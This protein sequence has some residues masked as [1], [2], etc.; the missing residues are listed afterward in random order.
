MEEILEAAAVDSELWVSM[1]AETMKTFPSTGSLNTDLN[2]YDVSHKIFIDM[3]TELKKVVNKTNDLGML[4]LEC[5]YLNKTA[6]TALV[7][8]RPEPTKHFIVKRKPKS[9]YLRQELIQK[10]MDAQSSMKKTS[11]PTVPLRS[12]GIPRKMTDTTPMKGIPSRVPTG[13]FRTPPTTSQGNNRPSVSRTPAGRKD[14]GIKLL[15]IEDQPLGYAAAK[16]RKRQQ[17]LEEQQ[18]RALESQT[19]AATAETPAGNVTPTTLTA[20]STTA[21]GTPTTPTTPD[22][23]AG[24]QASTVFSQPATPMPST[25]EK[26]SVESVPVTSTMA[27]TTT[28]S[29][30]STSANYENV[31]AVVTASSS[32]KHVINSNNLKREPEMSPKRVKLEHSSSGLEDTPKK[33]VSNHQTLVASS[34]SAPQTITV[35]RE[36]KSP[37]ASQPQIKR[38]LPTLI[39]STAVPKSQ[40]VLTPTTT[41]AGQS[42]VTIK[43]VSTPMAGTSGTT[44]YSN[45]SNLNIPSTTKIVRTVQY[46]SQAPQTSTTQKSPA[47]I[48]TSK[49]TLTLTKTVNAG[50]QQQISKP[51]ILSNI[52]LTPQQTTSTS[53]APTSYT[54]IN[55]PSTG[56]K[57][58]QR[59]VSGQNINIPTLTRPAQQTIIQPMQMNQQTPTKIVQIQTTPG[60]LNQ[61]SIK[62]IPPLISTQQPTTLLNFQNLQNIQNQGARKVTIT[63]Q[64]GQNQSGIQRITLS[65]AQAAVQQ[66]QQQQQNQQNQQGQQTQQQ[67]H[68]I[69]SANPQKIT[70]VMMPSNVKGKTIILTNPNLLTQKNSVILQSVGPG[71]NSVYQQIPIQNVS[72]LTGLR[73]ATI[74]TNP[75]GLIKTGGQNELQKGNNQQIPALV[76]TSNLSTQNIPGLTPVVIA[77]SNQQ[78]NQSL[79]TL[80]T[81]MSSTQPNQVQIRPVLTTMQQPQL[82]LIQRPGQQPQLVQTIQPQQRTIITQ[83]PQQQTV[84]TVQIQ[85]QPTTQVVQQQ[86]SQGSGTTTTVQLNQRKGLSLSVSFYFFIS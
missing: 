64:P 53:Q 41:I 5:Q 18:K 44:T 70:Q 83:Q 52:V 55:S 42:Y 45:L 80:I 73:G 66:Q 12:R 10:S 69:T 63:Q 37:I 72:G 22:Y 60:L 6:L 71:G 28:T 49:P 29:S 36:I 34:S 32:L 51:T 43:A 25:S 30:I 54:V 19:N 74:V 20:T 11:A 40:I 85:Q 77:T 26:S 48:L 39:T 86:S 50:Q 65:Q 7:G 79:P 35:T 76:P 59:V 17:D 38:T 62:N 4:P 27:T 78:Q 61:N 3:V 23:A 13:G 9:F 75:P 16:K 1:L 8:I 24:L 31:S 58:V 33:V 82:T 57:I 21:S 15:E 46:V 67:S 2:N 47:T 56:G 14:G 84:Q 81:K 68:V